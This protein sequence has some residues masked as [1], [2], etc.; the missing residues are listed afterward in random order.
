MTTENALIEPIVLGAERRKKPSPGA[1]KTVRL[2]LLG[3]GTVGRGLLELIERNRALIEERAG[4]SLEVT[5]IL[6]RDLSKERP[7]VDRSLLTDRPEEI[8][9]GSLRGATFVAPAPCD[10]VVELLGGIEP[11][12]SLVARA[13]ADGKSVVTAN[14]A[15]LALAGAEIFR[16]AARS[17]VRIG[18]EASVCAGIP[19]IRALESGLVGNRVDTLC[20]ILNGTSNFILTRMTELGESF[21]AAL[22]EARR[23]GFAE[24]DPSLDVDGHDAAQKLAILSELAFGVPIAPGSV[25]VEGIR[26]IEPEDVRAAKELGFVLKPIAFARDLGDALELR[27]EPTLLPID[28]TLAHVRFE[29]NAVLV[30]GD[31][32]GELIFRGKGAGSLPTAS[33][34]L[35]DIVDI[36]RNGSAPLRY[37]D[38]PPKP[39]APDGHARFYIRFPVIDVPGVIGRIATAL[40]SRGISISHASAT[41]VPGKPGHGN[42]KV[43]A[44]DCRASVLAETIDAVSRL[45]VLTGKPVAIRILETS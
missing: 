25:K 22:E 3:C 32:A 42:V 7:G 2:G 21:E 43:L 37:A 34:V 12:R 35:S 45:P 31:A 30:K 44:H 29:D 16:A 39:A 33:A 41:L 38:A 23:R 4:I 10:I 9:A 36:A 28:H 11:A 18:F 15:L 40:G 27:V 1:R 6:V 20:G 8:V 26:Q 19:I 13:I 17:G 5:K 24:A 14:K